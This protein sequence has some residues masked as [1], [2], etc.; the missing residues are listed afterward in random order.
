MPAMSPPEQNDLPFPVRTTART[1][2]SLPARSSVATN[3][4]RISSLM[5]LRTS[6][7]FNLTIAT[8]SSADNSTRLVIIASQTGDGFRGRWGRCWRELF[9]LDARVLDQ[10]APSRFLV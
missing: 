2:S 6:G 4:A 7:L 1:V 3:C 9:H 10:L 5:A 8:E